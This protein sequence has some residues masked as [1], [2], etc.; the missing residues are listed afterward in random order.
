MAQIDCIDVS[1]GYDGMT[2]VK[3]INFKVN[4]GDYLCVVGEN[5]SGKSTLIK[6]LLHQIAPISGEIKFQEGFK[7]GDIGYLPQQTDIQ[8]DFPALVKE[9]VLSGCIKPGKSIF[10][11]RDD[12]AIAKNNMKRLGIEDISKR[13]YRELSGGQQQRVL[14]C[15]ALC[16]A[17]KLLLMDEPVTGLDPL[18][19][20]EMYKLITKLNKEGMTVIM[21]SHDI[22]AAIK[23]ASH[24][25]HIA[26]KPLFFG[27]TEDYI[28][29]DVGKVYCDGGI[30]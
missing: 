16:A 14:L 11:S 2:I 4:E 23:Y 15:R 29:S 6:A 26:E 30:E 25:I 18:V 27:K 22:S 13:C 9:I 21:V 28:K 24:I 12:R 20:A 10:Y 17:K 5:G 8:R 19:T 3:D 7:R 1:L